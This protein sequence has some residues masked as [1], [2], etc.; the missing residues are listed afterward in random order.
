[1]LSKFLDIY[2]RV[3][4]LGFTF[5]EMC[6]ELSI[7]VLFSVLISIYS[8]NKKKAMLNTLPFCLGMLLTYYLVAEIT[9]SVYS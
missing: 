9:D 5:G 1:M 3:W 2:D 6:S 4:H 8:Q 7:W